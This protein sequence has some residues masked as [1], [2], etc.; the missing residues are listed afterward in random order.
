[1]FARLFAIKIRLSVWQQIE[2]LSMFPDPLLTPEGLPPGG[3]LNGFFVSDQTVLRTI[4]GT[5]HGGSELRWYAVCRKTRG[6]FPNNR[7]GWSY[8]EAEGSG[9]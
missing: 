7:R 8:L 4:V 3:I 5:Y 6:Q 1:M 9:D 2:P